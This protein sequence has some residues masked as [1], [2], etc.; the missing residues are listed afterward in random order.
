MGGAGG[1][2]SATSGSAAELSNQILALQKQG[3]AAEAHTL[4][5]QMALMDRGYKPHFRP[6]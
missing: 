6:S 4:D 1:G 3:K 5:L 2:G